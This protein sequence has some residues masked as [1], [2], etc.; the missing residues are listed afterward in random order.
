MVFELL[1]PNLTN[2]MFR[3]WA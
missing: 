3:G 2:R 1:P